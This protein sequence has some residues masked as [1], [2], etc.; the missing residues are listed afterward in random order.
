MKIINVWKN[1]LENSMFIIKKLI[2]IYSFISMDT[3]FPGIVAHENKK[4]ENYFKNWHYKEL[5]YNVGL[6]GII[7][8]GLT[9]SNKEGFIPKNIGCWQFNFYFDIKKE[10]FAQDSMNLLLRSGINFYEHKKKGIDVKTFVDLLLKSG[11]ISNQNVKW[12]S[13]HSEYDFG[14]FINIITNKPLPFE[15]KEF[16]YLLKK[17]FPCF[18]DIKYVGLRSRR[19]F[20]GLN[21]FADKFNVK[22]I[23]SV[24]QAGSDSLLT[25][26]VFF[27]LKETFFKGNIGKQHQGIIYGLYS[28]I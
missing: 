3:E 21:K 15:I 28:T 5:R 23:G 19:L 18:Y 22:R 27:K 8:L 1:N 16:F 7:Q 20:G 9:F 26:K 12:I 17:Y 24:H 10:M 11:I 25:L 4:K 13:F 2:P 6:L 14:Y